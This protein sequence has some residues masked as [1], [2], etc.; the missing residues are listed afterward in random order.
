[1]NRS[2]SMVKTGRGGWKGREKGKARRTCWNSNGL[3]LPLPDLSESITRSTLLTGRDYASSSSTG[4]TGR[5]HLESALNDERPRSSS[6]TGL[7]LRPLGS[8]LHSLTVTRSTFRDRL[9]LNAGAGSGAGLEEIDGD[10][11]FE[12]V[13]LRGS[14][15]TSRTSS[16]RERSK[17][18]FEE[19]GCS[20]GTL[21]SSER[22]REVLETTESSSSEGRSSLLG[23]V[24][25]SVL[26]G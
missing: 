13:S 7:A 8:T 12:I 1:M 21:T 6:L 4:V 14:T 26:R 24:E 23:R 10:R 22:T 19:I 17:E 11:G 18:G 16:S 5:L 25:V 20:S 9:R 15:G 2:V 3:S